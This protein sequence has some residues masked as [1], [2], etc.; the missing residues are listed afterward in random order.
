VA[1]DP[2][3]GRAHA[4]LAGVHH[5]E[6]GAVVVGFGVAGVYEGH[7]VS[8]YRLLALNVIHMGID[9]RQVSAILLD[10]SK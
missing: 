5:E 9:R 2:T 7:L 8:A 6:G 3:Q 10:L 1:Q 4:G